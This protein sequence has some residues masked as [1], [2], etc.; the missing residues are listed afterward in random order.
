MLHK[1][2][3]RIT[4]L[5]RRR[6]TNVMTSLPV[7]AQRTGIGHTPATHQNIRAQERRHTRRNTVA[8][9]PTARHAPA[10]HRHGEYQH[11]VP[12]D[13]NPPPYPGNECSTESQMSAHAGRKEP[14]HP[15]IGGNALTHNR[16]STLGIKP[17]RQNRGRLARCTR[18]GQ[19]VNIRA[20]IL[21]V[22]RVSRRHGGHPPPRNRP[23]PKSCSGAPAS[24]NKRRPPNRWPIVANKRQRL[25]LH[26]VS[27]LQT[28]LM[29]NWRAC[30]H[31]TEG[32]MVRHR[33]S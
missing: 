26:M 2:A 29:Q 6:H 18:H 13:S 1:A 17:S 5:T 24:S 9:A 28:L 25:R 7:N 20:R 15:H 21:R 33:T 14:P 23:S 22:R 4:H 32:N 10:Q 12:G 11:P 31:E 27:N 3:K 19:A 8:V 30:C 16:L